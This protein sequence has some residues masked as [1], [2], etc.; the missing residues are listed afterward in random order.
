MNNKLN[1]N[2]QCAPVVP[3]TANWILVLGSEA[4]GGGRDYPLLVSVAHF[5]CNTLCWLKAAGVLKKM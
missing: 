4:E 1:N 2:H 5:L 3:D